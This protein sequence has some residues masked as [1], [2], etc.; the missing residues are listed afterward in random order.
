MSYKSRRAP[1]APELVPDLGAGVATGLTGG[2]TA[3][4]SN[5]VAVI[6]TAVGG[7]GATWRIPVVG[8]VPGRSYFLTITRTGVN[9][10]AGIQRSPGGNSYVTGGTS[11][12]TTIME[13]IADT[14]EGYI[15][16]A[17]SGSLGVVNYTSCSV[18]QKWAA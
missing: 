8:L 14:Y 10:F 1:P 7:D 9:G 3:V 18:K 12:A 11:S 4:Y 16:L 15:F 2:G 6:T 13:F 5:G 17:N